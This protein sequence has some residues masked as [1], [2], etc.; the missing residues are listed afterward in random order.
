M[1]KKKKVVIIGGVATGPK[2]AART[3]RLL[4]QAEI[5]VIEQGSLISYGSCGL[6][7]LL[8][9]FVR[10]VSDLTTTASGI[11]R[12]TGY[13]I[14]E[15]N[16]DFL[17]RTEAKNID[18]SNQLVTVF[19]LETKITKEIPYD[20]LVLATGGKPVIPLVPGVDLPGVIVLH[21]PDEGEIIKEKLKDGVKKIVIIG[22]GLIGLEV[23]AAIGHPKRQVTVVE[24]ESQLLPGLLDFEIASL[25]EDNL[26]KNGIQ[27]ITGQSV[28]SIEKINDSEKKVTLNSEML[29]AELVILA[30]GVRPNVNL[31]KEAGL[32]IGS[33]GAIKVDE[34][35]RTSDPNIYAGG[36]C[37]ENTHLVSGQQVYVPLASI[38]NKQGRVIGSN[39]GGLK[40]VFPG[41]M[42]TGVFQ[43]SEF[44]G[45]KTGLTEKEARGLGYKVVT[46]LSAGLDS[47]HYHPLHSGGMIKLIA[48]GETKKLLGA[49]VAG[50]GELIKR[51]DVFSTGIQ[52]GATLEQM[53]NLDLGYAP[54]FATPIDLS[55]H[56]TNNLRNK[57]QNI[58]IGIQPLEFEEL[59]RNNP[60]TLVLDV[61][62]S[63]EREDR[64]IRA[65]SMLKI[66]LYELR[67]KLE[68]VPRKRKIV[69]VCEL[70][71]RGYEAQRILVGAGYSDV[72]NLE[73]G[74]YGL[75]QKMI[76]D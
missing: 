11:V 65:E 18:V 69:T 29:K 23:A 60:E 37:I 9:G 75:P 61:R 45:G 54:P 64:P 41:I 35:S 39:I 14:N 57:F 63:E 36:D 19:D 13:F 38:A 40:E 73:G 27:V 15:K 46:S 4:P 31:A 74:V 1:G 32:T 30:C 2:A 20:N 68:R 34:Y 42:G 12:D 7:L 47:A 24:R 76:S 58:L 26:K 71:I 62:T 44:N 59:L 56:A 70:G 53:A 17:V 50:Y 6:P 66:P 48:C 22:G 51:L 43:L 28:K 10:D 33:T 72:S 16:I 52:L 3:R 21:H 5:T 67:A 55:I 49:Q 8:G 25:V